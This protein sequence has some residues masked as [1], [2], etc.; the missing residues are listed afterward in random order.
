MPQPL[1]LGMLVQAAKGSGALQIV[2]CD[3]HDLEQAARRRL[4]PEGGAEA[5]VLPQPAVVAPSPAR[6]LWKNLSTWADKVAQSLRPASSRPATNAGT[7][8]PAYLLYRADVVDIEAYKN[9][10]Y[11]EATTQ[12]IR[13]YGGEWLAQ[14]GSTDV[15]EGEADVLRRLMLIRFPSMERVMAFFDSAD[16]RRLRAARSGIAACDLTV[17]EG[18]PG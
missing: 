13:A 1:A 16:Y 10:G 17:V 8:T 4:Q 5:A 14:G 18:I 15:L 9:G 12:L 6:S 3:S 7:S 11:F 2:V